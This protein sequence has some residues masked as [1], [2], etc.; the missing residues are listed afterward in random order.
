MT[1]RWEEFLRAEGLNADDDA[2]S[3]TQAENVDSFQKLTGDSLCDLGHL[4]LI[5]VSGDDAEE[6]LQNQ[7]T[8]DVRSLDDE[9]VTLAGYCN[10]KGRLIAVFRLWRDREGFL[11]Q[12]P[13]D[14]C[15]D[16]LQRLRKYV[17]RAKVELSMDTETAAF[18]V[19]GRTIARA[20]ERI[21]GSLPAHDA[22][23]ARSADVAATRIAGDGRPRLHVMGPV[24]ALIPAWDKLRQH[25][26]VAGSWTWARLDILA[27]V[28]NITAATTEAFVPQMVNLDQLGGV[29][30]QKGCY[31]G[32]EIVAR[33]HYLGNLKQRM[34]R[35]R[36]DDDDRPRP[37]DRVFTQGSSSPT[38]TIVDAQ[39]G[40]GSGWEILAVVRLADVGAQPLCLKSENGPKLFQQE[41]PYAA[42]A[43]A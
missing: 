20:L 9:H 11:M 7:L 10:P 6:F 14:L 25:A 37:G 27:G 8:N 23:V 36:T 38:G 1:D 32:Q 2:Y 17:L 29:N 40:A 4:T 5:R 26:T 12:L 39:P 19:C 34:G 35:F 28:P 16:V 13:S 15:D 30:F 24:S 21:T 3:H 43:P 31:P 42:F 41:L 18:G 33:M 22:R